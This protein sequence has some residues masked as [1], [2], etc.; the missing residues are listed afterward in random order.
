M[1]EVLLSCYIRLVIATIL[2]KK[3][4]SKKP[5]YGEYLDFAAIEVF[6]L[7]WIA[8]MCI[9][10]SLSPNFRPVLSFLIGPPL[11]KA[12][13]LELTKKDEFNLC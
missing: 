3:K 4:P 10:E 7:S 8:G 6:P 1:I 11:K 2:A 13:Q 9:L 12:W 5:K